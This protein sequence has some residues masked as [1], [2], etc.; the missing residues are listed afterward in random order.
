[1][2]SLPLV[3]SAAAMGLAGSIHCVAMCGALQRLALRGIPITVLAAAAPNCTSRAR[4]ATTTWSRFQFGR[5][6]GY[7]GLGLLAGLIGENLLAAASRQPLFESVWAGLNATVLLIGLVLLVTGRA[8]G[9]F[10]AATGSRLFT[11][12]GRHL[13][14]GLRGLA[15]SALPCGLLYAAVG[16][17]VLAAE[18]VAAAL[19]MLAFGLGTSVGL[20]VFE[21]LPGGQLRWPLPAW[22]RRHAVGPIDE[23][24]VFR[25][26]GAVLTTAAGA[27]LGAALFGFA[28][29]FC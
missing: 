19:T 8:P 12:L 13:G 5:L 15:W 9:W 10:A 23:R 18:P 3:L 28:H 21:S 27:G 11:A 26:N 25:V 14:P 7:S 17:A 22:A 2:N 24:L 1:M 4:Q 29:P 16:L 20:A 6:L